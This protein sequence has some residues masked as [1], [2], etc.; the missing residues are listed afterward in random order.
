MKLTSHDIEYI[1][2][3][4]KNKGLGYIPLQD[5]LIDHMVCEVEAELTKGVD[6]KRAVD[7]VLE[8]IHP[9]E[10]V[11]LQNKTIRSDN[12]SL[13]LMLT[14]TFRMMMRSFAKNRKYSLINLGGMAIG[15][16]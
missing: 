3:C 4:L 11:D 6:F 5:E 7:K 1:R 14:N 2:L 16:A 8:T 10:F 13:H 15:L 12:Y 9:T